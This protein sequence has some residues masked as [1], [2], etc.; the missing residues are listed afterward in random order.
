MARR[1]LITGDSE[2]LQAFIR[3][4]AEES[5]LT[6]TTAEDQGDALEAV[7]SGEADVA[8]VDG[9][10]GGKARD[11]TW[12]D[13]HEAYERQRE[14]LGRKYEGRYIAMYRGEVVGVS[15]SAEEA[16]REAMRH[17]GH[18]ESFL[19][20]RAGE[21]LPEPEAP[22]M[23][24]EAPR[25]AASIAEDRARERERQAYLRMEQQ[26]VGEHEGEF[27]ALHHGEAVG[28]GETAAEAV[29]AGCES[30]GRRVRLFVHRVG[31]PVVKTREAPASFR[32]DAPRGAVDSK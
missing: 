1:L 7:E 3:R 24:M 17:L 2:K 28:F 5:D 32:I 11:W 6:V 18:P 21:P 23:Q 10:A 30:V 27:V 22:G 25:Q 19:V 13:D 15:D 26:L 8:S 20:V 9:N 4:M 29:E 12:R 14:R 16:A 31:G